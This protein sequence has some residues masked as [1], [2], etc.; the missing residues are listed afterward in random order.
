M[1]TRTT[2]IA[3]KT[4]EMAL[5]SGVTTAAQ[6]PKHV[7]SAGSILARSLDQLRDHH[8]VQGDHESQHGAG[9]NAR[10]IN[11]SVTRRNVFQ[12]VA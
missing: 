8:V 3:R 11:G 5:I 10:H 2:E 1:T 7:E 9:K 4:V 6:L 12:G